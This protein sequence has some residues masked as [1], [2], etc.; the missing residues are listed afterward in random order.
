MPS[1]V[2][3][4]A[5]VLPSLI[6]QATSVWRGLKLLTAEF[7]SHAHE[8]SRRR[9][10]TI[11]PERLDDGTTRMDSSPSARISSSGGSSNFKLPD[12][13]SRRRLQF[14]TFDGNWPW[15]HGPIHSSAAPVWLRI[16]PSRLT[17]RV[18]TEC[19]SEEHTSELQSPMY[20][21]CRL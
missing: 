15:G 11:R 17:V 20:I 13:A 18:A 19:R 21:V 14:R 6:Q 4:S 10:S 5:L 9:L 7:F 2:A 8:G 3:M 1:I 12:G 16:W